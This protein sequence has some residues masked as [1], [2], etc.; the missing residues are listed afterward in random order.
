MDA[1]DAGNAEPNHSFE[2]D[3]QRILLRNNI[4][5]SSTKRDS[6]PKSRLNNFTNDDEDADELKSMQSPKHKPQVLSPQKFSEDREQV[7]IER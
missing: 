4:G 3:R 6:A 2:S 1:V 5:D 7:A